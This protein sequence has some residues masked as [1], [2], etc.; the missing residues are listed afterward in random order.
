MQSGH[1]LLVVL[2]G[3]AVGGVASAEDVEC[4]AELDAQGAERHGILSRFGR[5]IR[6]QA[7][8]EVEG[9]VA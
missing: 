4:L 7:A 1:A 3:I 2:A 5:A 9:A 6:D 8:E